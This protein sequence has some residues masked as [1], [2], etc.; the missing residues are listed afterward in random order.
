M[1]G[2]VASRRSGSRLRGREVP[3]LSSI[4]AQP[5]DARPER[6]LIIGGEASGKT[7]LARELAAS[8]GVPLYELDHIAWQAAAD[9]GKDLRDVFHPDYQASEPVVPRPMPER[10][11]RVRAIAEAPRWVAEGVF[12]WWTEALFDASDMIVWLDHVRLPTVVGRVLARHARSAGREVGAR[13][14]HRKFSRVND[15]VKALRR[16][17][18]VIG[19]VVRFHYGRSDEE[20]DDYAA[21]TRR[22]MS[23]AA[24]GRHGHKLVHVRSRPQLHSL[25]AMLA[26]P[27][28]AGERDGAADTHDSA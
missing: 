5:G 9:R 13:T 1:T 24:R 6:I 8:L 11:A 18:S 27:R 17:V 7:T 22:A 19:R 25:V 16:L 4:G 3:D 20:A 28:V 26:P 2:C 21:I 12:L 15:Y 10:L 23:S 14:G